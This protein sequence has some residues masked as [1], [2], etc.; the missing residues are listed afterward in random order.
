M[1]LR[2]YRAGCF[3]LSGRY[4]YPSITLADVYAAL[5]Y[6][7]DHREEIRRD[8]AEGEAFIEDLK[9]QYPSKLRERLN[10]RHAGADSIPPR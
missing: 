3:T 10:G 1:K 7:H 9:P 5:V 2:C 4:N 6:Y 8:I